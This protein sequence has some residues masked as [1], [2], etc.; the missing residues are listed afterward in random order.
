MVDL[1]H[2]FMKN[3]MQIA[4]PESTMASLPVNKPITVSP[5]GYF[6]T[7]S[8]PDGTIAGPAGTGLIIQMITV[9]GESEL[10]LVEARQKLHEVFRLF[11]AE[12][13]RITASEMRRD[14]AQIVSWSESSGRPIFVTNHGRPE[15]VVLSFRLYG[16]A[17]RAI[18]RIGLRLGGKRSRIADKTEE[19]IEAETKALS[20]RLRHGEFG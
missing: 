20:K 19:V 8:V 13:A 17:L 7:L 3:S 1:Q 9:G 2:E 14:Y 10:T 18:S 15:A 6:K 5:G 12:P 16:R 4:F 11:T